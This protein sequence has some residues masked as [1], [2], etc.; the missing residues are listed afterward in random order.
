MGTSDGIIPDELTLAYLDATENW[1]FWKVWLSYTDP[2]TGQE[3]DLVLVENPDGEKGGDWGEGDFLTYWFGS[4]PA[5]DDDN[6]AINAGFNNTFPIGAPLL[7][8]LSAA[9]WS[10]IEGCGV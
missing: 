5:D 1:A 10:L 2:D 4:E 8:P 9:R 3:C 6:P 7:L